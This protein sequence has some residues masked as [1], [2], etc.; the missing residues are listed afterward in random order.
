[1]TID[2]QVIVELFKF[3]PNGKTILELGTGYG[4]VELAKHWNVLSVEHNASWHQGVS[5]LIRVPLIS[6]SSNIDRGIRSFWKRFPEASQWYD[7]TILAKKL[8]G[9]EYDAIIVDGPPG[10]AKRSAM[11]WYYDKIFDT[12]V[13]VI[14]DDI[15]RRYDWQVASQ[16]ARIKNVLRFEVVNVN[17]KMFAVIK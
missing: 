11:W 15:H 12:S 16:I 6:A 13:P 5:E 3:L 7:P 4:T 1:M 10:G 17:S 14:V 8:E 2:N 9:K